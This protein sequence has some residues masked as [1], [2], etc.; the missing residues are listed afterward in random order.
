MCAFKKNQLT[1]AQVV[2]DD[3][4]LIDEAA[5]TIADFLQYQK[6]DFYCRQYAQSVGTTN[7]EHTIVENG[8]IVQ[9]A[10]INSAVQILVPQ[11]LRERLLYH[12]HH[13]VKAGHPGQHRM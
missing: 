11:V 2:E 4:S 8:V 5:P 10:P 1:L 13:P 6:T 12:P 9:L 7:V 3:D